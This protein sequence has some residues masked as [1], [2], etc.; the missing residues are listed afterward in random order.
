LIVLVLFAIVTLAAWR[1]LPK[2]G[3]LAF[4]GSEFFILLAPSS[5]IVPIRTEVA[6]ERRMYLALVNVLVLA[7]VGAEWLRRRYLKTVSRLALGLSAGCVAILLAGATA[8]R[9]H[10]YASA[11]NLWRSGVA[12]APGNARAKA[13][14]G[15]AL[16][17]ERPPKLAEAETVFR[18][19]I[20]Q[21]TTCRYGCAQLASVLAAQ[22]RVP[23]AVALLERTLANDPADA[24]AEGRLALDLMKLGS[25]AEAIRHLEHVA[26]AHP[27]EHLLVILGVANLAVQR[28][29]N[30]MAAFQAAADMNPSDPEVQRLSNSLFNAG[31][32]EEALPFLRELAIDLA[33]GMQ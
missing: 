2:F 27:S 16:S 24:T 4:I 33:Q 19:A 14:L 22:G 10:I 6:A 25:F 11:E 30:A 29:M 3:W 7:V 32:R 15:Y 13:N 20:A 17:R 21:D 26:Q 8:A 5:S 1:K 31:R 18:R 28:Q 23:E 9:S 12:N